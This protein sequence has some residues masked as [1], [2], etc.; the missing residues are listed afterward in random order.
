MHGAHLAIDAFDEA[1]ASCRLRPPSR[2]VLAVNSDSIC[3]I[4]S[5]SGRRFSVALRQIEHRRP[6]VD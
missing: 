2:S 1:P 3:G 5:M 6:A 4:A